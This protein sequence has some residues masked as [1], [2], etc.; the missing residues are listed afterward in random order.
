[1]LLL[2]KIGEDGREGTKRGLAWQIGIGGYQLRRGHARISRAS[3]IPF[4]LFFFSNLRE[5]SSDTPFFCN[6]SFLS[7]SRSLSSVCV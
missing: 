2:L 3:Q 7:V 1:M 6:T 4:I 5:I